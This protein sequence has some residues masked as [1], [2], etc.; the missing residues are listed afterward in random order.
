MSRDAP[1]SAGLIG[2]NAVLQLLPILDGL[3]GADRRRATLAAAGILE[4]PDGRS[5]IPETDAARLHHQ[6]RLE[7]PRI[8][9][10]LTAQ[11]GRATAD[12]ILRHRIPKPVQWVLRSLPTPAAARLLSR[13]IARHAWTFVGSGRLHVASPWIYEIEGNPLIEGE[14]SET[15]LCSWH[16]AVFSRLYQALVTGQ[17][18]CTETCCGAQRGG[19]RC[20]FELRS[21]R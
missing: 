7:E 10:A 21:P 16:S 9:A 4:V 5:M 20:R 3:G 18:E 14:I 6:L 1:R 12:Y 13:A 2:P 8:A 11:A 19:N 15:C 17:I